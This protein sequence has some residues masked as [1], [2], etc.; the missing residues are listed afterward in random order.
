[1]STIIE[2][3]AL[4]TLGAANPNRDEIGAPKTVMYGGVTRARVSSQSWKRAIRLDMADRYDGLADH[5]TRTVDLPRLIVEQ[6][7]TEHGADPERA[8]AAVMLMLTGGLGLK[9]TKTPGLLDA[10]VFVGPEVIARLARTAADI[11]E[12]GDEKAMK[13]AVADIGSKGFAAMMR[14]ESAW[15]VA[16]FGR[17]VANNAGLDLNVDGAVR[18]AHAIG[19]N[20]TAGETD[21]YATVDEALGTDGAAMLGDTGFNADVYYRYAA[22][23]V[24]QLTRNLGGD[25][26]RTVELAGM[27][28]RSFALAVPGGHDH[29]F[30]QTGGP[31]VLYMAVRR[32]GPSSLV[33]AFARPVADRR[34]LMGE[35]A[36][37]MADREIALETAYGLD[38]DASALI[39]LT[40]RAGALGEPVDM[41]RLIDVMA[42]ALR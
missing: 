19:V 41:T 15:D 33:G 3:H 7:T 6:A 27:F 13:A 23:D 30:A 12:A 4:E 37:R 29:Q 34:D 42:E 36:R 26:D 22:L 28:A 11:A 10:A 2:L 39:D 8:H 17:M 18:M 20:A 14:A 9:S 24:D 16:L 35:A 38:A 21:F 25:L 32:H 31:D 40:G 1:M 5:A